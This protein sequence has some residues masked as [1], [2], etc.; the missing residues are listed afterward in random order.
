MNIDD[1]DFSINSFVKHPYR[2]R[3]PKLENRGKH[4]D[5]DSLAAKLNTQYG[6]LKNGLPNDKFDHIKGN[7]AF[8]DGLVSLSLPDFDATLIFFSHDKSYGVQIKLKGEIGIISEYDNFATVQSNAVAAKYH[9]VMDG[10]KYQDDFNDLLL[11]TR[12][13]FE[14]PEL[15]FYQNDVCHCALTGCEQHYLNFYDE[16]VEFLAFAYLSN[17]KV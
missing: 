8:L 4:I 17:L 10:G 13:S 2:Y 5:I 12:D 16:Y 11:T 9:L 3:L 15:I 7:Y 14:C 1:L 6:K